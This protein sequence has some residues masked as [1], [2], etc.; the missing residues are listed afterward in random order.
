MC[1]QLTSQP[2]SSNVV[3][4]V[5]GLECWPLINEVFSMLVVGMARKIIEEKSL[6][7]SSVNPSRK[8]EKKWKI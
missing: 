6:T 4:D 7:E 2:H 5:V 8:F 3:A 1:H